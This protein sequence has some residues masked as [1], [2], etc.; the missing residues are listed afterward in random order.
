MKTFSGISISEYRLIVDIVAYSFLLIIALALAAI[1]LY[2]T[3]AAIKQKNREVLTLYSILTVLI[4][5]SIIILLAYALVPAILDYTIKDYVVYK[6]DFEVHPQ[7]RDGYTIIDDGTKLWGTAGYGDG[8][9]HGSIVYAKRSS[10]ILG[11]D[12]TD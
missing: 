1:I 11:A 10:H 5:V 9:T 7:L 2:I 12:T 3:I 8:K 6:G 4:V